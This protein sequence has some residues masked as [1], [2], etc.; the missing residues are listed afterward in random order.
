MFF[1]LLRHVFAF[2]DCT[3]VGIGSRIAYLFY[4]LLIDFALVWCNL[5]GYELAQFG[6]VGNE[7]RA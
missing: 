6:I 3:L 7:G 5:R 4:L 2:H 1:Y